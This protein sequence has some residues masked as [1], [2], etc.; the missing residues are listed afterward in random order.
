VLI[1]V[2]PAKALDF[3]SPLATR[4][5]TVPTLMD[6]AR[7]LAA[8]MSRQSPDDLAELMSISPALAEL[9]FERFQEWEPPTTPN[10]ARPAVLAF[11]G[12]TYVGL[13]APASFTERDFTH[14]QKVLRI[15]SGLHG[16]LRPLDL[17]Q[18]YRLEMGSKVR[19]GRGHDL[20]S[21][22][23]DK[24]TDQLNRDLAKSPGADALVNL[25]SN[26]Y[27]GAVRPDRIEGRVIS[28]KFLDAKGDEDHKI[29]GFFAKR[30]RG[31]MAGWIIRERITTM[32][33]LTDFDGD[34]YVFAPNRSTADEPVFIRRSD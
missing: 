2:S 21:F 7:Q 16:V 3:E 14:A 22:W 9:N 4:K 26:E 12:D 31:A 17:I 10:P 13:D 28:P 11:N 33:A 18:P 30:A 19:H 1:V 25:A 20:Y 32:S 6:E 27:F 23:G 8:I 5:F 34:G 15:L 29:V 24:I